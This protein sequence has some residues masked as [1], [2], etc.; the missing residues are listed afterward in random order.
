MGLFH[1]AGFTNNFHAQLYRLS[2]NLS[3]SCY[4]QSHKRNALM[5]LS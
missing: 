4:Y 5:S 1:Y 3:I 2:E